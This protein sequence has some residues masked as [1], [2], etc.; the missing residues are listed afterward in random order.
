[1]E[2]ASVNQIDK[3]LVEESFRA[4]GPTYEEKAV[5]QKV[6]SRQLVTYLGASARRTFNKAIEI[7]CCTGYLT[8]FLCHRFGVK[9]IYVNDLV[10]DFCYQTCQR[11]QVSDCTLNPLALPGDIEAIELPLGVDLVVSSSTLQWMNDLTG[12]LD[13]IH[14]SLNKDGYIAFSIFGNGTM[15]EIGEL[16]GRGLQYRSRKYLQKILMAR[17]NLELFTTEVQTLHFPSVRAILRH[18][19]QTGVGGVGKARWTRSKLEKFEM[20]YQDRF[21]S[22]KGLPVSYRSHYIVATKAA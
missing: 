12:L 10:S 18:I 8:E 15:K 20:D 4:S 13:R 2:P 5:V 21:G 22:E 14:A 6:I 9:E 19:Q 16:S 3:K 11:L 7:G 1:M 17:F